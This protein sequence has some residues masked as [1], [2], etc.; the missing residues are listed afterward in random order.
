MAAVWARKSRLKKKAKKE[1][2]AIENKQQQ[3]QQETLQIENTA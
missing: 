2:L 1:L 3:Q